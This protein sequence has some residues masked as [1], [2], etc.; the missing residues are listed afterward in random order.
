VIEN[1]RLSVS[2]RFTAVATLLFALLIIVTQT[3]F[4][5]VGGYLGGVEY[6]VRVDSYRTRRSIRHP[7]CQRECCY[8]F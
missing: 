6:S 1:I 7:Y 3:P 5:I 2:P 8:I 4:I